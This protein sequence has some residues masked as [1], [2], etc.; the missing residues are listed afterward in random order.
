MGLLPLTESLKISNFVPL[1]IHGISNWTSF[2]SIEVETFPI[3]HC[4]LVEVDVPMK[5]ALALRKLYPRP[6]AILPQPY[7][8]FKW[9]FEHINYGK[10][11]GP[12]E[13][14]GQALGFQTKTHQPILWRKL[15]GEQK[16]LFQSVTPQ[17]HE[18]LARIRTGYE[19]SSNSNNVENPYYDLGL[20]PW[21]IVKDKLRYPPNFG[22]DVYD[23]LIKETFLSTSSWVS[24]ENM[25][26][27]EVLIAGDVRDYSH[28][29]DTTKSRYQIQSEQKMEYILQRDLL[30]NNQSL[31]SKTAFNVFFKTRS[32]KLSNL[33]VA[34][35]LKQVSREWKQLLAKDKK[36]YG[37]KRIAPKRRDY[38]EFKLEQQTSLVMD[39]IFKFGTVEN[40]SGDW[41]SWKKTIAGDL[42][43]LDRIYFPKLVLCNEQ[44]E[45]S[46]LDK[47]PGT[48]E[49]IHNR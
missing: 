3:L 46:F 26:L 30:L 17:V 32:S 19:L 18:H 22:A 41:R 16:E 11:Y 38:K 2:F 14:F 12:E 9:P 20:F 36:T 44:Y 43:Y 39:Y 10:K 13:L 21:E 8:L 31:S 25:H 45:V 23:W 34:A 49:E 7:K 27:G 42:I 4:L 15:T 1:G 28:L 37:L 35:R 47:V 48:L 6:P 40:F 33:L 24:P 5:Y 29:P